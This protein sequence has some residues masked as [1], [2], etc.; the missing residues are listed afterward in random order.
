MA[1]SRSRC[2]L[3]FVNL[4]LGGCGV[5]I[6]MYQQH[7]HVIKMCFSI[8]VTNVVA[9]RLDRVIFVLHVC[10]SFEREA[11]RERQ[12]D[13]QRDFEYVQRTQE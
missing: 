3:M 10:I 11:E 13:R 7:H 8:R 12:T 4:L 2:L 5:L 9:I 6:V 1:N